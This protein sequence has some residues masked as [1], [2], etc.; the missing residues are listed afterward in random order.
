MSLLQKSKEI[1]QNHTTRQL[2]IVV[3][4]VIIIYYLFDL[5][6]M[7]LYTRQYQA[8]QVPAVTN[9]SFSAA[10]KLLADKGLQPVK[11]AEKYDEKHPTG[12][13]L[14]QN[15][16]A[17]A[18]VKKGRRIYL[19][20]GKGERHFSMPRLIGMAERDARFTLGDQGLVPGEITYKGDPF[21][22]EG[23]VCAQGIDPGQLV[24]VG[25]NIDLVVS[26]G[27]EPHG[28][29]VPELVG[30]SL[31]DALLEIEESGLILGKI[32]D[33]ETDKVLPNTVISQSLQPGQQAA[34]GDTLHIV[35]TKLAGDKEQEQPR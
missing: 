7:P 13:V 3:A 22:P 28:Y 17:G 10:E 27:I 25:Q 33:Q 30:K 12:F 29:I 19:T 21:Y 26:S 20:V 5:I 15:P 35:V 24:A 18:L 16:E 34:K 9:L 11:G 4:T 8:V 6:V 1:F 14:F 23:V 2:G 32:E 31:N